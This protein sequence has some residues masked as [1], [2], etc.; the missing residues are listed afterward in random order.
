MRK[1][2]QFYL[3]HIYKTKGQSTDHCKYNLIKKIHNNNKR[4]KNKNK[5]YINTRN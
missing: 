1:L 4:N 5:K 2:R 3:C